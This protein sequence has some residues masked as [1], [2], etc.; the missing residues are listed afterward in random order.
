MFNHAFNRLA[1]RVSTG[2]TEEYVRMPDPATKVATPP[3]DFIPMD[4]RT[5]RGPKPLKTEQAA[6]LDC[7]VEL[8]RFEDFDQVFGRT[9][10]PAADVAQVF[11]AA[12]AWTRQR[13][14]SDIWA[15]YLATQE[16]VAWRAARRVL[17]NIKDSFRLAVER[18]PGLQLRF[19]AIAALVDAKAAVARRASATRK[20]KGGALTENKP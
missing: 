13:Q 10:P 11:G 20:R 18:E 17:R 5:F 6:L 2:V 3:P 12:S 4:L 8:A 19:P 14:A 1:K 16:G 9:A 15:R 7:L